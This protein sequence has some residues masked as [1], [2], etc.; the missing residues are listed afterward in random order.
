LSGVLG[1]TIGALTAYG[2]ANR[3]NRFEGMLSG[4]T[5]GL[6]LS[7][8]YIDVLPE[9]F[10][11]AGLWV[12]L[13]GVIGGIVTVVIAEEII[14]SKIPNRKK[15]SLEVGYLRTALII[16]IALAFHNIP[17]GIAIG[18]LISDA[19][20]KGLKFGIVI[21]IHNIPEGMLIAIPFK[22]TG[23]STRKMVFICFVISLFMGIGG[24]LGFVFSSASEIFM[25]VSLG[26]AAGIMLFIT[27]GEILLKSS[28]KWKGRSVIASL[29]LGLILGI[30]ISY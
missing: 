9:A 1:L 7:I 23:V 29:V 24:Y 13:L 30:I 21:T 25:S 28:E 20:R 3:G 27:C 19:V 26:V 17:E 11:R 8:I 14:Q 5:G 10:G 2:I 16:A 18:S 12:P 6:M 15:E 4:F 22:K